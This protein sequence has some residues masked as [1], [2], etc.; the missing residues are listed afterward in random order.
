M[1]AWNSIPI[2]NTSII[3]S[4]PAIG[5]ESRFPLNINLVSLP[6]LFR[7]QVDLA[8]QYLRPVDSSRIFATSIS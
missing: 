6:T 7:N 3:H 5:Q 1:Y 4:I 8:T 2:D